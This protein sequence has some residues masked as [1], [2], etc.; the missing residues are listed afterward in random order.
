MEVATYTI[1]T[2]DLT[3][4]MI[5]ANDI[6]QDNICLLRSGII[7]TDI[8][9]S[10]IQLLYTESKVSVYIPVEF[11]NLILHYTQT[12]STVI[13]TE[14]LFNKYSNIM[15]D[16]LISVNESS[17]LDFN[18]AREISKSIL[19]EFKEYGV[20]I[21]NILNTRTV[22]DYLI[23]HSV[24]VAVLSSMLGKWLDLNSKDLLL[25]TYTGLLHDIGKSKLDQ[26]ILNKP[27]PLT[28]E[29]M[30]YIK[31]H[32]LVGYN[33]VKEIPYIN[34]AISV[35][36]LT[37]H[38]RI[39]GSGYP[40]GLLDSQIHIFSKIIGVVDTFDALTSNRCYHKKLSAFKSLDI[41]QKDELGKLDIKCW[42]TFISHMAN[43]FTGEKVLLKD[44][45]LGKIIKIDI[46]NIS[47]PLI[48]IDNEFIDL[49]TNSNVEIHSI[50]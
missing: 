9:I 32:T 11:E 33:I 25:L 34:E 8:I 49:N 20:T 35:G 18:K 38:E 45:R 39:D 41:M 30:K 24:N 4:G 5:L 44:G 43:Y 12:N 23:R 36:I 13:E 37:H 26:N 2:K 27:Y 42:S 22:D 31:T 7:L 28:K 17:N 29:D 10:K 6:I 46:N 40:L 14:K 15:N 47:K 19:H 16:I 1:L 50:L 21:K 48:I 3:P